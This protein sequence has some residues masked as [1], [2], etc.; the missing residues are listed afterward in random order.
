[1]C[2]IILC[3]D[4]T[5]YWKRT[6]NLLNRKSGPGNDGPIPGEMPS[7]NDQYKDEADFNRNGET[8]PPKS[9]YA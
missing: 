2:C 3:A 4:N 9:K 5:T 1:M 6:W 7:P 8:V